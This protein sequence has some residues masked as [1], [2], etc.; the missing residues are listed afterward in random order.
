MSRVCGYG[1]VMKFRIQRRFDPKVSLADGPQSGGDG[2]ISSRKR[3]GQLTV[4]GRIVMGLF[5]SVSLAVRMGTASPRRC[6]V[7]SWFG[8]R[9]GLG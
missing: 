2:P 3:K 1:E 4:G 6:P 9:N 5:F 8:P 7:Q